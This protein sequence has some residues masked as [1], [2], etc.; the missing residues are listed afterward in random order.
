MLDDRALAFQDAAFSLLVRIGPGAK[1]AVPRLVRLIQ[2]TKPSE[3][4]SVAG[5]PR[6][7]TE[8]RAFH[9]L[10][11]IG[12]DAKDAVPALTTALANPELRL[13]AIQ[14]LGKIG[15]AARGALPAIKEALQLEF[16][17]RRKET[18]FDYSLHLCF[19]AIA[20][21]GS[22][23]VPLLVEVLGNQ[24][25]Q[26]YI[27]SIA[28][29]L[30]KLG[31]VARSAVP[32]LTQL[33]KHENVDVRLD[34]ACALWRIDRSEAVVP[35]LAELVKEPHRP[36]GIIGT[37]VGSALQAEQGR[38]EQAI[39]TLGEIGPAAKGALPVLEKAL[40][41]ESTD[42]RAAASEAI[43]KIKATEK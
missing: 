22:D 6:R 4:P 3:T 29:E 17:S 24:E 9:I 20:S 18:G 11:E 34:V 8:I 21:M 36:E 1:A 37:G 13:E 14:T 43:K 26:V 28:P 40:T 2:E 32:R 23:G 30:G 15:P 42:L 27:T 41:F 7:R 19:K 16:A 35:V 33:L 38:V 5:S 25:R 31:P 39:R 12:P 10:A